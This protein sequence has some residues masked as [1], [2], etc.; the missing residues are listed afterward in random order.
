MNRLIS[1]NIILALLLVVASTLSAMS[2]KGADGHSVHF[3]EMFGELEGDALEELCHSVSRGLDVDFPRQIREKTGDPLA[4]NHRYYGH[5]GFDG[6]IPFNKEGYKEVLGR[7]RRSDVIST[8][9]RFVKDKTLE[10]QRLTG[11]PKRQSHALAG[12][13]YDNHLLVDWLP[14]NT[15]TEPLCPIEELHRDMVKSMRGLFGKNSDYVLDIERSFKEILQA[16]SS[17][18]EKAR[19]TLLVLKNKGFGDKLFTSYGTEL[20]KKGIAPRLPSQVQKPIS[21][22][23]R[24]PEVLSLENSVKFEAR[25]RQ[26]GYGRIKPENIRKCKGVVTKNGQLLVMSH[27]LTVA[28]VAAKTA[29]ASGV[30]L[31]ASE[32]A[33]ATYKYYDGTIRQ[34]ELRQAIQEAAIKGI[35]VGTAVGVCVL[36]GATPHGWCVLAV[37]IGAYLIVDTSLKIWNERQDRKY[38]TMDDLR[39][40]GIFSN[41][42]LDPRLDTPLEMS[43]NS[44]LEP[45]ASTPLNIGRP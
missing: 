45:P 5:W 27:P 19:E 38:L 6:R 4:S 26:K 10:A 22:L 25:I 15:I 30:L 21:N 11:L 23:F 17:D 7:Y 1:M 16:P 43:P 41:T 9:Q 33:F 31:F 44:P 42:P 12:L 39:G 34:W 3:K 32:S 18:P 14:G 13:I 24:Q 40:Y 37:S 28:K 29:V 2:Y 35:V 20:Q 8:W 36:L